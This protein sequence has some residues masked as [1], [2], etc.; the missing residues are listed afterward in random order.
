[1]STNLTVDLHQVEDKFGHAYYVGKLKFP[2]TI[3][4]SEGVTFI[5][6]TSIDGEEQLQI[7]PMIS[8]EEKQFLKEDEHRENSYRK[9]NRA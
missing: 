4:L 7:A 9:N 1:M 2:G 5:I 3:D 6:F 8:K